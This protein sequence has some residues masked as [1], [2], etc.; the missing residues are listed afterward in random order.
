MRRV[1]VEDALSYGFG[2]TAAN[3]VS[4]RDLQFSDGQWIRGKSID[5][6]C[7]IG[8]VVVTAEDYD[9]DAKRIASRVN[10][11]SMQESSTTEMVFSTA[12]I[13]SFL[14]QFTTL[15]P[16]DLVLTGTPWGVGGFRDPPIF[17]GEGDVVEVEVEGIGVLR[18]PVAGPVG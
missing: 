15:E 2:Y 18:N 3:D 11:T 12:E 16:G 7:P 17:L 13:L 5:T 9:P 1:A 6:F 10:G 4:A 14:S 8:P